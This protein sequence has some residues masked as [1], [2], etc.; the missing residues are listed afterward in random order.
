M[1]ER[2]LG[3]LRHIVFILKT[4]MLN[5]ANWFVR[6]PAY[7]QLAPLPEEP[8]GSG[9]ATD[10]QRLIGI[11]GIS[12][13][14]ERSEPPPATR[15]R[16]YHYTQLLHHGELPHHTAGLTSLLIARFP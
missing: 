13:L 8:Y 5:V 4:C 2:L 14:E 15:G 6:V 10:Y 3:T 12:P 1:A 9:N 16:K 11:M 7:L